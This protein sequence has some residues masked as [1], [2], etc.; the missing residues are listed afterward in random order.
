MQATRQIC[1]DLAKAFQPRLSKRVLSAIQACDEPTTL[2]AWILECAKLSDAAFAKLVTGKPT[3]PQ[4]S[5]TGRPS[6]A[7]RPSSRTRKARKAR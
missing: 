7:S 6:R 1:I 3:P 4:R 2:R 5:R